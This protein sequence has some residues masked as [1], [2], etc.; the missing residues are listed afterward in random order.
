MTNDCPE[1]GEPMER[2]L[3]ESYDWLKC[4]CCGYWIVVEPGASL[5]DNS[6]KQSTENAGIKPSAAIP[7]SASEQS[8]LSGFKSE[9]V[10]AGKHRDNSALNFIVKEGSEEKQ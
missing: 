3:A 7:N 10:K 5:E 2:I 6:R 1:C 8:P 9:S 4:S